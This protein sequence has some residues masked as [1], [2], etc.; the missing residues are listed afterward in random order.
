MQ[1]HSLFFDKQTTLL[2]Q[3]QLPGLL[4]QSVD[5]ETVMFSLIHLDRHSFLE[6]HKH[7]YTQIGVVTKG[8][9]TMVIGGE[10]EKLNEGDIYKI[11]AHVLHSAS[12]ADENAELVEVGTPIHQEMLHGRFVL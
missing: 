12:T 4:T 9:I 7:S 1:T 3:M 2:K 10:I 5:N 11:P 8:S 6:E